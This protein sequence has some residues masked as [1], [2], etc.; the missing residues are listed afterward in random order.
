L[1]ILTTTLFIWEKVV[2]CGEYGSAFSQGGVM[3][4]NHGK[5]KVNYFI[6]KR[7]SKKSSQ[8]ENVISGTLNQIYSHGKKQIKNFTRHIQSMG[9][10]SLIQWC[11]ILVMLYSILVS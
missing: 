1:Y 8:T 9:V 5:I 7:V 6:R 3:E 4:N 10:S 2:F 11:I